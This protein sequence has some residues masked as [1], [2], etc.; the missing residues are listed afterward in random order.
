VQV[1]HVRPAD[2]FSR[3][4][5]AEHHATMI[6]VRLPV[7]MNIS[8][9]ATMLFVAFLSIASA[10]QGPDLFAVRFIDQNGDDVSLRRYRGE[11]LIVNFIFASCDTACPVQ[12]HALMDVQTRLRANVRDRVRFASISVDPENDTAEALRMYGLR[13]GLDSRQWA[14]LTTTENSLES[15]LRSVG[16]TVQRSGNRVS[17]HD[18]CVIVFDPVGAPVIAYRQPKLDVARVAA[19]IATLYTL[20][21]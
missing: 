6:W 7:A 10:W 9:G 12:M 21:R 5:L 4:R 14:L 1:S 2:G 11:I 13:H 20:R 17:G 15:V 19:D 3:R 16:V 8:A 18:L